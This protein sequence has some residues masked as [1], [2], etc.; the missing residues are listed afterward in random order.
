MIDITNNWNTDNTE[1]P[2]F[3]Y[4]TLCHFD[5]QNQTELDYA[6]TYREK[7]V[8]FVVYNMPEVDDVV[9]K[10]NDLDYLHNKLGHRSYR[11]ETSKDNHFMYWRGGGGNAVGRDGKKWK[12]PTG[13]VSL[14][15]EDWM[16]T[17]VK[18][19][20][21]TLEDR[22]HQYFRVSSDMGNEWLFDELP[23]FQPHK[24]IFLVDPKEQRGIHCRFGMRSVIAEA[25]F[26]GSRNAVVMLGGLRR[27][28]LTH[29]N[30]CE[31]MHM[32]PNSHP[33]GRHSEVDWSKPDLERFPNFAKIVGNEVILQPGDYL[34]VP[35]YWI[36]TIGTVVCLHLTAPS[37]IC[38]C[39]CR[40][41]PPPTLFPRP[42]PRPCPCPLLN[43]PQ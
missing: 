26:D 3:H 40:S 24:N 38:L 43:I 21:K 34:Y 35:T 30:Q 32:L 37:L 39:R 31:N 16:E 4:D 12:P 41:P 25:H 5:Y 33:S 29:P 15:F 10:W 22:T 23:F 14:T 8:P 6:Y 18:G 20:N 2:P 42:R 17:A 13:L 27:W 7:E 9:K 28:I 1:I 11:T 36:H 19:Q